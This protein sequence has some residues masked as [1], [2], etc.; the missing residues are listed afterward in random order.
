LLSVTFWGYWKTMNQCCSP[1]PAFL[2]SCE[3]CM[4][5]SATIF[6]ICI[7]LSSSYLVVTH[8]RLGNRSPLSGPAPLPLVH[9]LVCSLPSVVLWCVS[10]MSLRGGPVPAAAL[11]RMARLAA[12]TVAANLPSSA[13]HASH[14]ALQ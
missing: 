13:T 5:K 14:T 11:A 7:I 3:K 12:V 8:D 2:S 10:P 4:C 6:P 9:E 1:T